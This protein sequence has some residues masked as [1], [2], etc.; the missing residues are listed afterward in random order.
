MIFT[1]HGLKDA[2]S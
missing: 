2:R 1:D